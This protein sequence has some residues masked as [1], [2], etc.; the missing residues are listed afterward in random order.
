MTHPVF[1]EEVALAGFGPR[2]RLKPAS[3]TGK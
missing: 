3:A 2:S 1:N